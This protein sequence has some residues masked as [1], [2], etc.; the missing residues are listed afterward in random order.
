[1]KKILALMLMAMMLLT[2]L[3]ALADNVRTSGL[4]TYEI[5]GNGTITITDF[6]WQANGDAD[7]YIPNLIDGYTVTG[8]A[9]EAFRYYDEELTWDNA[10]KYFK[11]QVSSYKAVTVTIPETIKTIGEKAFWLAN[12]SAINIPNSVELIGN[13]AF[14]GCES[15]QFKI[16]PN[17][18]RFA[19]IDE[20][21]YNKSKKELIAYSWENVE[22]QGMYWDKY[23]ITIPEGIQILGAYSLAEVGRSWDITDDIEIILPSSLV[24][25]KDYA[26]AQRCADKAI[27][28]SASGALT[29]LT[30]IGEGAFVSNG[31]LADAFLEMPS[32]KS[33]GRG[34]FEHVS[35]DYIIIFAGSPL[36][37]IGDRAFYGNCPCIAIDPSACGE[38]GK[39]NGGLGAKMRE[40]SDFSPLLTTIPTGLN[41][42]VTS[43]PDT[44]TAIESGAFT[45]VVTDFRLSIALNDIAVDGFPKGSTFIVDAGSYAELWCSENG[46]GYSIEGQQD[47]LSWLNN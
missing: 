37:V 32:V 4:Y 28:L 39:D 17:H 44:I 42:Q 1:M 10:N 25:I 34:A 3:P 27:D 29:K 14:F 16:A 23:V 45:D 15:C 46:F 6:D 11:N 12:I 24:D 13:G 35:S 31:R 38:I 8:I 5:K 30:T 43:L 21:L 19:V 9:D 20:G 40:E 26:L 41:P 2:A 18:S 22:K 36:D 47:D 33:I 7:I